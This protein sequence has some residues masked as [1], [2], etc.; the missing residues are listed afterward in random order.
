MKQ[1]Q[2]YLLTFEKNSK[3][4]SFEGVS[5]QLDHKLSVTCSL[6]QKEKVITIAEFNGWVH[7]NCYIDTI[8]ENFYPELEKQDFNSLFEKE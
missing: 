6:E 8:S 4:K 5:T 3:L 2:V 1:V 7:D